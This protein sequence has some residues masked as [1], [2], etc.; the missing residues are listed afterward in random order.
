MSENRISSFDVFK[1]MCDENLDIRLATSENIRGMNA[2]HKGKDTDIT[3]GVAGN[4]IGAVMNNDL[5]L[6]LLIWNKSQY[7]ETKAKIEDMR[8]F[9]KDKEAAE[10]PRLVAC[11]I[12][13]HDGKVLLEKRAPAGV[14]GLDNGWDLPGGKVEARETVQQAVEREILEEIGIV[15]KAHSLCPEPLSS[16]WSYPGKGERHWLLVGVVC[17]II[18]REPR[19]SERLQWFPI[20]ALPSELLDADKKLIEQATKERSS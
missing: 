12:I 9:E 10:L 17:S 2:V 14:K 20:D 3:I 4:V 1:R 15:V 18:E 19:I 13:L 16:V 7:Q 11:A 8:A 6:C 5:H